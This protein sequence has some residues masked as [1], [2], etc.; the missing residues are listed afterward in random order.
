MCLDVLQ[1]FHKE[2]LRHDRGGCKKVQTPDPTPK[3]KPPTPPQKNALGPQR[4]VT[5]DQSEKI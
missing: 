4:A 3:F 1:H 5:R 2:E